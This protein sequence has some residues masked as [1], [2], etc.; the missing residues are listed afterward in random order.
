MMHKILFIFTLAF[1]AGYAQSP[2]NKYSDKLEQKLLAAPEE[3]VLVWIG[4]T[5]KNSAENILQKPLKF[6]S[7]KSLER[8]KKVLKQREI[9]DETDLPLNQN[10]VDDLVNQGF[11]IKQRSKWFNSVSGYADKYLLQKISDFPFVKS[12]KLV[13]KFSNRKQNTFQYADAE[14]NTQFKTTELNY[15]ASSTQNSQIN[16]PAVHELGYAGQGVTICVMDAGFNNLNHE[17]FGSI[18]I[19]AAYDFVNNDPNVADENDMGEGS[20]GT[21]VLSA[22]GG[23]KEGQLIG[24]AYAAN[25]I[26][27]K[28]ENTDTETPIEEDNWIA[29]LEWADSIGVDVTTTS[30]GYIDFDTPF[31]SYTWQDMDGNTARI[32]IAADLAVKKGIVVVNSA[33]NEGYNATHNTLG[34]PADGDSVI[35]A[36][37]VNSS[38]IRASFSSVGNTVDGRIKPDVMAPGV[39]IRVASSVND[40]G[41]GSVNGTSFSCPLTAG[42][43]AQLLSHNP[44]LTPIEIRDALR[45]TASNNNNPNREYGWGIIDALASLN[46][47]SAVSVSNDDPV[48]VESFGLNQNFPNPFNPATTISFNLDKENYAEVSIFNLLGEKVSNIFS[49]N[50][51]AGTHKIIFDGSN[52]SSG[53]Y[54]VRLSS[55]NMSDEIKISLLK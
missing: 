14:I 51:A 53:I 9:I 27:A 45:N 7:E 1:I 16:I 8:R 23:F 6:I 52:L 30:L 47:N 4:F 39:N 10:Y 50:L 20:H 24:P 49:G 3:P 34:A 33:G 2:Q 38:G 29:A 31:T 17:C 22:I 36:G 44:L 54:I 40:T 46:Y 25:Y 55:G 5:D 18:N 13:E 12:I 26:L 43:A 32:T 41:Y 35:T 19:I 21:Y 15:G 11:K 42:V 37:A 28:T 48:N